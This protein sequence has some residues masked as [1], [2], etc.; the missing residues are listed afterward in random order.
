MEKARRHLIRIGLQLIDERKKKID[1]EARLGW[2][3][4]RDYSLSPIEP[5]LLSVLGRYIGPEWTVLS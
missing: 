2:D 3:D 1:V 5:D 4:K